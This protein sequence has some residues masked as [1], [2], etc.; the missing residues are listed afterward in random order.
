MSLFA[1]IA[2]VADALWVLGGIALAVSLWRA[3]RVAPPVAALLVLVM[4]SAIFLSQLGAACSPVHTSLCSADCW[5]TA[6]WSSGPSDGVDAARPT[7]S[8]GVAAASH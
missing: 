3:G 8:H 1:A 4:P 5:E 6:S 2:A 7:V